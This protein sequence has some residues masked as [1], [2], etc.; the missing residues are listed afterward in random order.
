VALRA[1]PSFLLLGLLAAEFEGQILST[2]LPRESGGLVAAVALAV[3]V[4]LLLSVALHELAHAV[5][6]RGLGLPVG[7]I[8]LYLFGG[9]TS[10]DAEPASASDQAMVTL[11][12][13]LVNVVLGGACAAIALTLHSSGLVPEATWQLAGMNA[14]L[15][16]YNLVPGLP[17][18]GGQLLRA[19]LWRATGDRVRALRT[20]AWVGVGGGIMAGLVGL[21]LLRRTHGYSFLL[22]T[23]AAILVVSGL[24]I[25]RASGV[26]AR[27][28]G[29]SAGQVAR[30]AFTAAPDLPLSHRGPARGPR[31]PHGGARRRAGGRGTRGPP[32]LGG[33]LLGRPPAA[34]RHGAGQSAARRGPPGSHAPHPLDGVPRGRRPHGGGRAAGGRPRRHRHPRRAGAVNG[35]RGPLR[36]GDSVQL[37]DPKGRRHTVVL[38]EGGQFHTHR[39][40]I[41]HDDLLGRPEGIVVTSSGATDY[42]ALRPLLADFVLSMPRGA[43]VVYPKDAATIVGRADI[44]P[45]ARVVEAG[46]GSGAL[47]CS[48]LR[49][50]GAEGSLTSFERRPDFAEVARGNVERFFG[51]APPGWHLVVGEAT[52]MVDEVGSASV[53]RVVLDML[54]PWEVLAPA[55]EVLVPGGVLC[56][57]VATTTQ[58]ARAV[59]DLR[60]LGCFTEPEAEE[61]LVRSWHVDG[62]AVRPVHRMIGHTGFLVFSRRLAPGVAAPPRRRRPSKGAHDA[63]G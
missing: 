2:D 25:V 11:A 24:Q 52:A 22:L 30:R 10:L 4:G 18:D 50:V 8:M 58:L 36:T 32:A 13:P 20:T 23:L 1:S 38:T 21:E 27:L 14:L 35:R 57:Y 62:L 59:E 3:G 37:T 63:P 49:A 55:A 43:A 41:S 6:G 47:S 31:Q 39:G 61:T 45:G 33:G 44:F 28:E 54:A 34:A 53:D 48:L 9:L 7:G 60:A 42:V 15:A 16:A 46:A 26:T 19:A 17:L 40:I 12:G 5:V 56:C 29:V 51:A